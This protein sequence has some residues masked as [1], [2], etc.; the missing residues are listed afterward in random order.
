MAI[1]ANKDTLL[2]I[3]VL[4]KL[5]WSFRRIARLNLPNSHH[6]ITRL[7]DKGCELIVSGEL[8]ISAKDEKALRI[9]YCGSTKSLEYLKGKIDG[10]QCGGGKRAK[11]H[12]YNDEWMEEGEQ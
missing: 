4:R 7:F 1:R 12:L 3:W 9:R 6:T 11:Q 8:P 10:N 5:G 2:A